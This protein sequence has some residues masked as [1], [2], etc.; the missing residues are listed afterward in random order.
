MTDEHLTD[1]VDQPLP[2]SVPYE[3]P[4]TPL[5]DASVRTAIYVVCAIAGV[6]LSVAAP[7]AIAAHAPEWAT[8]LLS[9]MAGAI[10]TVAAAFGVA[11]NPSRKV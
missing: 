8:I 5:F 11:Y 2:G 4:Y 6:I 9:A 1:D 3:A 7:V 10:P